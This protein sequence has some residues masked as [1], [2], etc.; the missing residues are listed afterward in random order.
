M[1]R[2]DI[3]EKKPML[4]KKIIQ[5]CLYITIFS[6][7]WSCCHQVP[8]IAYSNKINDHFKSYIY[9]QNTVKIGEEITIGSFAGTGAV[10]KHDQEFYILTAAHVCYP[11]L[12]APSDMQIPPEEMTQDFSAF[13]Y[14]GEEIGVEI[15]KFDVKNDLC[16]L[17][18]DNGILKLPGLKLAK[19]E[20][21]IG[22][23]VYIMAGP[24][25]YWSPPSVP[26]FKGHYSGLNSF[27]EEVYS[28]HIG[29]GSSGGAV[30]NEK[31]Q[32]VG[33]ATAGFIFDMN[34]AIGSGLETIR[35]FI[36]SSE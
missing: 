5:A 11:H 18:F 8:P 24:H 4:F 13:N 10:I 2:K 7:L 25:G 23:V 20:P 35:E 36:S 17:E 34:I 15:L 28:L 31:N 19:K 16:L 33:I 6:F 29:P 27:G 22:D 26:I 9:I 1:R 21:V 30:L 3:L 32:L 12:F 14:A